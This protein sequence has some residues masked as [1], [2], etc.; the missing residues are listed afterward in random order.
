MSPRHR[1]TADP[2]GFLPLKPAV[3][4]ILVALAE[5]PRHGYAII[6]AVQEQSNGALRLDTG[7]LYRHLKRLLDDGLVEETSPRVARDDERR[8]Y[9]RPTRLG[10]RVLAAETA[11]L[12]AMLRTS[13]RLNP[14][15]RS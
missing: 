12:D 2:A 10:L 7:P 13:R 11:R 1:T 5:T 3:L 9:Y 15:S 4:A 6:R 14:A 8:R